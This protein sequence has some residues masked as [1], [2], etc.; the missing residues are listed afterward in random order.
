MVLVVLVVPIVLVALIVLVVLVVL[1]VVAVLV[2]LV[3]TTII[4][5]I[6]SGNRIYN[7]SQNSSGF[8]IISFY[9]IF[10]H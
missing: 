6:N 7:N 4:I 1:V 10:Y 5:R 3:A 9:F 2:V 8:H